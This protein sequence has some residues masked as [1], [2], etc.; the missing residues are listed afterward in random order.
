MKKIYWV[1][2]V[3]FLL[4]GILVFGFS[5]IIGEYFFEFKLFEKSKS[6]VV[7]FIFE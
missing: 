2:L 1:Y 6:I 7:E 4:L 3:F 5:I